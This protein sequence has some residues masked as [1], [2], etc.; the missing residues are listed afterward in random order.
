MESG[1]GLTLARKVLDGLAEKMD[2]VPVP[3]SLGVLHARWLDLSNF[4][5]ALS[6]D[7]AGPGRTGGGGP[8]TALIGSARPP[9]ASGG[10][11]TSYKDPDTVRSMLTRSLRSPAA[12]RSRSVSGG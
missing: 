2:H 11:W 9:D 1:D 6:L 12:A 7:P 3:L 8:P 10:A 5:S 4:Y